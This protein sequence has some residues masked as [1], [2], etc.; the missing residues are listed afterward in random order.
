MDPGHLLGRAVRRPGDGAAGRGMDRL[1][2]RRV[3]GGAI[4][5]MVDPVAGTFSGVAM[6]L[7]AVATALIA[8]VLLRLLL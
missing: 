4:D 3:A 2:E 7:N 1:A 8:P 6:G 5:G